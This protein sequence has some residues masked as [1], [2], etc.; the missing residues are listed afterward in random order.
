MPTTI[1]F[2]DD[3]ADCM[4]RALTAHIS[5]L[6]VALRAQDDERGVDQVIRM[7]EDIR[8]AAS[9]AGRLPFSRFARSAQ[10][11]RT[12]SSTTDINR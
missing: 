6:T 2:T 8:I 4:R 10:D 12:I 11:D 5:T 9:L 1:D 3:E 7:Y